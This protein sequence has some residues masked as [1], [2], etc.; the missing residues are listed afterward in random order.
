[1]CLK[2]VSSMHCKTLQAHL[3]TGG[4]FLLLCI[5]SPFVLSSILTPDL[6]NKIQAKQSGAKRARFQRWARLIQE[7]A[8]SPESTKLKVV[9]DFFNR[10]TYRSDADEVGRQ[11]FWMTPIEFIQRGGGDCEDYSIAKYFTLEAM[12][13]PATKLR[14]TYV[15]AIKL[16]VAHM[17]LAYY[18]SPE[19]EPLVLDNLIAAIKPASQR[20]DLRPVYS[21]NGRGLWLAR[22]RGQGRRISGADRLSVWRDLNA[23]MLRQLNV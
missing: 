21:F 7:H 18:P 6:I 5:Y 9:N 3:I 1:M 11:D 4:L 20:T 13:V 10:F 12:G 2:S 14:I 16:N 15:K 17:V 23:R 22:Q 8:N 19:A